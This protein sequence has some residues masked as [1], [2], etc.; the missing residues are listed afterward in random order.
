[1]KKLCISMGQ[2]CLLWLFAIFMNKLAEWLHLAVPGSIIGLVLLF[3]LLQTGL[4]K[5]KWIEIGGSWLVAELLLF[6]IPSAVGL[7]QYQDILMSNGWKIIMIICIS[8]FLV[9]AGSGFLAEKL[10]KRK[11]MRLK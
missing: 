7:L 10:T 8:T 2:V 11:E 6:F 5:L 9:M 1:M 4:I 3:V